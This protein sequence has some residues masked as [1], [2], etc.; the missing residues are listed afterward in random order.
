MHGSKKKSSRKMYSN[1]ILRA[2]NKKLKAWHS[3]KKSR[4]SSNKAKFK[5][6]AI[7]LQSDIFNSEIDKER[8][9]IENG[10]S[11]AFF[12]HIKAKTAKRDLIPP[13]TKPSVDCYA[14]S[15]AE[16]ASLLNSYFSSVFTVDNNI[17]PKF[18]VPEVMCNKLSINNTYFSEYTVAQ[19]I[20]KLKNACSPGYDGFTVE[21]LKKLNNIISK[22]LALLFNLSMNSDEI[23]DAWKQSIV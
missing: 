21:P 10:S 4:S 22:P 16:K 2:M 13:L 14:Y 11:R 17:L 23:P 3:L 7:D 19:K 18:E 12:S 8:K 1:R 20:K 15:D 5:K 6:C 9:L